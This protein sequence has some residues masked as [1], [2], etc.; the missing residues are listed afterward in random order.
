MSKRKA[1][2]QQPALLTA[3]NVAKVF[4]DTDGSL[5]I[6]KNVNLDVVT[7]GT[8]AIVGPSGS[9]KSTLLYLLGLLDKPTS[10]TVYYKGQDVSGLSDSQRSRLRNQ[11]FGFVYQYHHLLPEFT[12]LENVLMPAL[13]GGR[14][15][16]EQTARAK[17]L[18]AAVGLE[19][20]ITH[21]PGALS[22]GE[23]QRVALAR[24]LMNR[25]KL[26]LAD[27]PTGNL[28]P[29]TADKVFTL[30]ESM[31]KGEDLTVLL[32]THNA[33]L[34]KRCDAVYTVKDGTLEAKR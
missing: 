9:G 2:N 3:R 6:L 11:D 21:T 10:G 5:T 13:I 17:E 4:A 33:D 15:S 18:L 29:K 31:M 32:V 27:E 1:M 26:L 30:F 8:T 19:H 14:I 22:G 34:A 16:R 12:A 7:G 25:P 20:R 28:D 24:A 23:Q